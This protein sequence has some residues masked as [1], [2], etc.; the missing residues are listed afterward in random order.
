MKPNIAMD[1][2]QAFNHALATALIAIVCALRSRPQ[3]P[4][5]ELIYFRK[6]AAVQAPATI[7]GSHVVLAMPDGNVELARDDIRKIVPGFWPA[8]EWDARTQEIARGRSSKHGSRPP[9]GPSRT[10]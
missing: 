2:R 5:A 7:E 3:P 10:A 8:T 6:G 4:D 1:A 9:G